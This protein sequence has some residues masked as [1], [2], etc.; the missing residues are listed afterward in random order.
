MIILWD[1]FLGTRNGHKSI[2]AHFL[3]REMHFSWQEMGIIDLCPFLGARNAFLAAR[4]VNKSIYAHF[5]P[6]EMHFSRQEMGIN[7]YMLIS[8]PEKCISRGKK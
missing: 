7:P 2:Y 6:R 3:A 1:A 4:N 5:L 8:C